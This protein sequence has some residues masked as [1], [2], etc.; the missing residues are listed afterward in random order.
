MHDSAKTYRMLQWRSTKCR[1]YRRRRWYQEGRPCLPASQE[2]CRVLCY[3]CAFSRMLG[4]R[5]LSSRCSPQ[6]KFPTKHWFLRTRRTVQSPKRAWRRTTCCRRRLGFLR[7][8]Y[9]ACASDLVPTAKCRSCASSNRGLSP[10]HV[11]RT[12]R[13]L[14]EGKFAGPHSLELQRLLHIAHLN[15]PGH[16]TGTASHSVLCSW[17]PLHRI[18]LGCR[19]KQRTRSQGLGK[20][21][22]ENLESGLG[23]IRWQVA[24]FKAVAHRK[25]K[26]Q[27]V[28][29]FS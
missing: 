28:A 26:D 13:S 5:Y 2:Y 10:N 8:K 14:R 19:A 9:R 21:M 4:S 12:W 3:R 22:G 25:V 27:S 1:G 15:S 29:L 16:L 18:H 17:I 11:S 6:S 23:C 20:G 7:W 24:G